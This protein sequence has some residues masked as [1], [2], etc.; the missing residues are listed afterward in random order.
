MSA[1]IRIQL[2][3][4]TGIIAKALADAGVPS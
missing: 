2:A 1:E 4:L 3:Q